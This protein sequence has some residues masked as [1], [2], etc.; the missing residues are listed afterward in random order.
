FSGGFIDFVLLGILP[1][2]TQWWLVIPVGLVY[3]VIYYFLFRFFITKFKYKT[4]GREDKQSSS[5]NAS[6]SELPFAVLDAMG[7]QS[8]IQHLDACI[9]RLRVEVKEKDKVDVAELKALGA[10]GVLE[11]GNNMQAIFGPKSDQIKHDMSLIMKGE[12]TKPSEATVTEEDEDKVTHMDQIV[13]M[14]IAAPGKGKIIPLSEVPDQVFAGKM[15]GD[16]VGFVPEDGEIVAPFTGTVKTIFPTKH[17]IGLES[18][19]GVELL[20]HIGIDTVKLNGEGF[21]SK[22]ETGDTVKQG[23]TLML[24]DFDYIKANAPSSVTPLVI[25]NLEDRT[26]QIEDV[27]EVQPEQVIM[28]VKQN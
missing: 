19:E 1:N 5:N 28:K 2:Q 11:V 13:E 8:N 25:T 27:E 18:D 16:G 7:G 22:V 4:P 17:A 6:A 15:M 3:A 9:T 12:I 20:I 10:S 23:Q 24:V 21:E 26:L 14:N